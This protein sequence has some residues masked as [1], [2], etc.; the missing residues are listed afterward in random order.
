M[1]KIDYSRSH[2]NLTCTAI[3]IL[4]FIWHYITY[5]LDKIL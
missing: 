2:V 5:R 1:H 4:N 3:V